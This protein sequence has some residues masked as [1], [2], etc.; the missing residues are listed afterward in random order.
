M[1][2]DPSKSRFQRF[3][4]EGAEFV[5]ETGGIPG[6]NGWSDHDEAVFTTYEIIGYIAHDMVPPRI[7]STFR[8]AY[9]GDEV[10]VASGLYS[11]SIFGTGGLQ[12]E[13]GRWTPNV[14]RGYR[15]VK[16]LE[17]RR[18]RWRPQD[19]GEIY[20]STKAYYLRPK[21]APAPIC[22]GFDRVVETA[23]VAP[24]LIETSLNFDDGGTYKFQVQS[25][26]AELVFWMWAG[27]FAPH[28]PDCSN[29]T[30]PGWGARA[31]L[32]GRVDRSITKN[33]FGDS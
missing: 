6:S 16:G 15:K 19:A 28:H 20:V 1:A 18:Q 12:Q 29:W 26:W 33:L 2:K 21:G 7:A 10:L 27:V 13:S 32:E 9:G 3:L 11:R 14:V 17:A 22:F 4:D 8:L 24:G 23:I 5:E 30:P 25:D 31:R